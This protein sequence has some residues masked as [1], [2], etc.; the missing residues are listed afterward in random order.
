MKH[1][2]L[3]GL[4]MMGGVVPAFATGSWNFYSSLPVP[5]ASFAKVE[6]KDCEPTAP[7]TGEF[8]I[9]SEAST[10]GDINIQGPAIDVENLYMEDRTIVKGN[11]R[12][13]ADSLQIGVSV[14]M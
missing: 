3:W 8:N 1:I 4:V 11:K 10:A 7:T 12:W 5:V 2:L 14:Y 13:I 6:T 9:G